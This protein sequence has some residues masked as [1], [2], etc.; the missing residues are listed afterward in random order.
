MTLSA[1]EM[2]LIVEALRVYKEHLG[3]NMIYLDEQ[4]T[5]TSIRYKLHDFLRNI[6]EGINDK[7]AN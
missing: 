3:M 5:A 1:K 6:K 7:E 2:A 4:I